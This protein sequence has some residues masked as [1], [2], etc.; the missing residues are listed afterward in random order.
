[1]AEPNVTQRNSEDHAFE[2]VDWEEQSY[3]EGCAYAREQARR[4]LETLDD[5]LLGCKPKGL[6]VEGFR[7]RTLVTRFGEVVVRRRMYSD[8][9]GNTTFAL[10]DH[11]G[12]KPRQQSSPPLAESMV[13]MASMMPFRM[14]DE[15]VSELTAGVLSPMTVHRLL[16][17]VGQSAM[18]ED[19]NRWESCF[20]RGEDVCEGAQQADVLYTEADG[21]W[22]HLQREE[23]TH[24][25]LKCAIAYLGW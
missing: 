8:G 12:W 10:D 21:V 22:I 18:D 20:E 6:R 7:E 5:E 24:Y 9:R 23:R 2:G 13:S 1:M 15:M 3:L 19:R 11:L 16:S 25:E 4:R 14:V 17:G